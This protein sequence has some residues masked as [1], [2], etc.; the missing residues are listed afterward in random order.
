MVWYELNE[1]GA[2]CLG[3]MIT[4]RWKIEDITLHRYVSKVDIQNSSLP[5]K[6]PLYFPVRRLKTT[7]SFCSK[8]CHA[9]SQHL[10]EVRLPCGVG[11]LHWV[12]EAPHPSYLYIHQ[13]TCTTCASS[14]SPSNNLECHGGSCLLSIHQPYAS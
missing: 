7:E 11:G 2:R 13:P 8:S 1:L 14:G 12:A 6:T 4:M 3:M 9:V 10:F 5:F